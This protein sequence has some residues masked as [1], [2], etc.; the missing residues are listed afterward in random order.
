[1]ELSASAFTV[2]VAHDD[3][4]GLTTRDL[5]CQWHLDGLLGEFAWV[6]PQDVHKSPYGPA[7]VT[8][9]VMGQEDQVELMTLLG[10]RPRSMVRIVLLHLLTHENSNA[11]R[12]VEACDEIAELV[13]RA[14]PR[15]VREGAGSESM[16]LLRINLMVPESDLLPQDTDLIEPGWE[17]NA[18][19]S[20]EDRP[21]LD[22]MSVFVRQSV[23]LH[24]HGLAATAAVGGLWAGSPVGAFDNHQ[25]DSTTGGHEVVVIRCQARIVVGDDRSHELAA[26][27][28]DTVQGS[29][30]GASD[31]VS[32]AVPADNPESVVASAVDRLLTHPEWALDERHSTPLDRTQVSLG[33]LLR[34]WAVFQ[35]QMP[36]AVLKFLFGV[37]RSWVEHSITA[38]TVGRDAGEVGRVRPLSPDEA[39]QVAE[40]RMKALAEELGPARLHEE[41]SSW[42]QAT[43]SAWRELRE[44]VIGLV[45]GSRLPDRFARTT[46]GGLEE[47]LPPAAVAPH[48]G[49]TLDLSIGTRL[50]SID[51]E[52]VAEVA[53]RLPEE[54]SDERVGATPDGHSP[55]LPA[56]E[57]TDGVAKRSEKE[58]L[59]SWVEQR[60][61]T[62]LWSLATRV[63]EFRRKEH[64]QAAAA[65]DVLENSTPPSTMRLQTAQVIVVGAWLLALLATLLAGAWVWA[66][67]REDPLGLLARLP[68]VNWQNI[69]RLVLVVLAVLLV[70]GTNYFQALRAY[71]W[72]VAQRMHTIR[73]A[74]DEYVAAR[75]Q[76]KRWTLMYRGL[77]EWGRV[78]GELLHRPW[79]TS[80]TPDD[81]VGQYE[82]LPAAVAVAVPENVDAGPD[83]HLVSRGVEAVC[84]RGWLLEEFGRLV[85][86]SR[87]NDPNSHPRAGDL[88]ADLDLGL[89]PNGPRTELAQVAAVHSTKVAATEHLVAEVT[90]L[91]GHGEVAMPT[92]AVVRL[93]Q[94]SAGDPVPDREFFGSSVDLEAPLIPELFQPEALIDQRN[95]PEHIVF[96]LPMG[97]TRPKLKHSEV[98]YCGVSTA[99]RVD[100]SPLMQADNITMFA[101]SSVLAP[102]FPDDPAKYN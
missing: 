42:G 95:V 34:N 36:I 83:P 74:S 77:Q 35:L 67:A 14:M 66:D 15:H 9:T 56:H 80:V 64:A 44:L 13:R 8:A 75:Q 4:D 92:Q 57:A 97:S 11:E 29:E 68:E 6:T 51:V 70:A 53:Q 41:A 58:R 71:E 28:I 50:G 12:L 33:S 76:E 21:D 47:V 27:V 82:G 60:K 16:R 30:F 93:G 59:T 89:R 86:A 40:H 43:P 48:P 52:D 62:L 7:H 17:I 37:G 102:A 20:P 45:D 79:T 10:S 49:E 94:Y 32:W 100:V 63:C 26:K 54:H 96:C 73:Q 46:R 38:A 88:P 31:L 22:R 90:E 5:A 81:A 98:H 87:R 84:E 24:G 1:M 3:D 101:R 78:F 72:S 19:V 18:I 25:A 99:T 91:I 61:H 65:Q 39:R 69:A 23:N 55:D 85:A 2:V